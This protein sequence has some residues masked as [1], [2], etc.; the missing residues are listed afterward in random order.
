MCWRPLYQALVQL[1]SDTVAVVRLQLLQLRSVQLYEHCVQL[2]LQTLA[3]SL[4]IHQL[5][6]H[7]YQLGLQ[8]HRFIVYTPP[9]NIFQVLFIQ[10]V[11]P[12]WR[13]N[14]KETCVRCQDLIQLYF[15]N[16]SRLEP[17]G[18]TTLG[19]F[20]AAFGSQIPEIC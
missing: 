6:S 12:G 17:T 3:A 9:S 11:W 20:V 1:V 13:T 16:L 14:L 8:Q 18:T 2:L 10:F 7:V 5:C 19:A 15:F 4:H